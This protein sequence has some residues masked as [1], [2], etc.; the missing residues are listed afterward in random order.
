MQTV[1]EVV[2][3]LNKNFA[4]FK[5]TNDQRIRQIE[6]KGS[7]DLEV[8]QKLSRLN[9]DIDGISDRLSKLNVA[10]SRPST[11]DDSVNVHNGDGHKSAFLNY[12]RKGDESS[13]LQFESKSL[14][15]GSDPDGGYSMPHATL[16]TIST[17]IEDASVMRS[18]A[19]V[20]TIST[21]ALELLVDRDQTGAGWVAENAERTETATPKFEK[22]RIPVHE[23]YA[24]P[25]ATQKLLD[26]STLNVESWLANK[27]AEKMAELENTAFFHGNGE[28]QPTGFL[29]KQIVYAGPQEWGKLQGF[30]TGQNAGFGENGA[31]ILF[32]AV[33]SLRSQYLSGAK[34]VMSRDTLGVIRTLKT[35]EGEYLWKPALDGDFQSKLLGFPV[36]I[37]DQMP[38]INHDA[39]RRAVAFGNFNQGYQI[40]DRQ[41]I[42]SLRDP[43]SSKPYVEFYTTKR[44]GGDLV[45]SEAIKIINFAQ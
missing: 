8:E 19:N 11:S 2:D 31:D 6:E 27:V 16:K 44:V 40:V 15:A 29:S 21:D 23:M 45:N 39:D 42:R 30:K 18:L 10:I 20:I 33:H 7:V 25:C 22:M 43:Y 9:K 35:T 32:K 13:I 36:V 14:S 26:D 34:W 24:K 28:G 4:E 38:S 3:L 37:C 1:K 41:G 5:E 12:I 17:M